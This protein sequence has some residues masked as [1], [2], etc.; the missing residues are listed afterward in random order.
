[1]IHRTLS[2]DQQQNILELFQTTFSA[3]EGEDEGKLI[4]NLAAELASKI[5]NKDIICFGTWDNNQ[6]VGAIFFTELKLSEP[7]RVYMLAPVAVS[8]EYQGRGIGQ[9][10]ICHGIESLKS[11]AIDILVTYGDPN[12]YS[13]VGFQPLSEEIIP[14][15]FKLSIPIGWLG[16]CRT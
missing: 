14:A 11:Q 16:A 10:L 7:K 3:S 9:A 12:F 4:G 6:L 5:N 2:S 8:S 1:M 15:P 13:K